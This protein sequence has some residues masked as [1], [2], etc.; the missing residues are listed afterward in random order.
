MLSKFTGKS[1]DECFT[2]EMTNPKSYQKTIIRQ[3]YELSLTN[4]QRLSK[5][6]LL[7]EGMPSFFL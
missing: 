2:Y 5:A 7:K 6:G 4:P 1:A 3:L